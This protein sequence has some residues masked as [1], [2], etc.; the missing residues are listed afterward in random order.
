MWALFPM[1]FIAFSLLAPVRI[2]AGHEADDPVLAL[3][4]VVLLFGV[5]AAPLLAYYGLFAGS[6]EPS[7]TTKLGRLH[8]GAGRHAV[9]F[10]LYWWS[11][12]TIL[13]FCLWLGF[14]A[15]WRAMRLMRRR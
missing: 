1:A 15:P 12:F 13:L 3:L 14:V 6:L 8:A 4:P 5:V 11:Y 2:K 9:T 10:V 7:P